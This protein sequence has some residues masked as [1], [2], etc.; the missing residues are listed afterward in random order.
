VEVAD[1]RGSPALEQPWSPPS[2]VPSRLPATTQSS[3]GT[4][5]R[6]RPGDT[7]IAPM[8][9]ARSLQLSFMC[10][11]GGSEHANLP[12]AGNAPSQGSGDARTPRGH[13][14]A[15][16]GVGGGPR[17]SLGGNLTSCCARGL[18]SSPGLVAEAPRLGSEASRLGSEASKLVPVAQPLVFP[19]G[20]ESQ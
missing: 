18:M 4:R 1:K 20:N 5:G 12:T 14:R 17:G 6:G 19:P 2:A 3:Q 16:A 15:P 7:P 13:R 9:P 10:G 8:P 11:L